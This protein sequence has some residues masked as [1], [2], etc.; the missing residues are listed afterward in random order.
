MAT[1]HPND[2]GGE[3]VVFAHNWSSTA[4]RSAADPSAFSTQERNARG[5]VLA[6][7]FDSPVAGITVVI[8]PSYR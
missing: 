8:P 7:S 6:V 5:S 4:G 2:G 3:K 1:H